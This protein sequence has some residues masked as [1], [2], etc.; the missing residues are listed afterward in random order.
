V[1]TMSAGTWAGAIANIIAAVF[2]LVLDTLISSNTIQPLFDQPAG[3][4]VTTGMTAFTVCGLLGGAAGGALFALP[5]AFVG[6]WAY[7]RGYGDEDDEDEEDELIYAGPQPGRP[8]GGW[9]PPQPEGP[10]PAYQ[11]GGLYGA[12]PLD[13]PP[14]YG[15]GP[16]P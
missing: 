9:A 11:P 3:A 12:P 5:G 13:A 6:R 8:R 14:G 16:P 2:G 7:D 10:V 1:G 4:A 15:Y